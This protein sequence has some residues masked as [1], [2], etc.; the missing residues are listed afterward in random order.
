MEWNEAALQRFIADETEESSKLDY[1]AAD[2][3]AKH[4]KDDITKAVSA[5]ANTEGGF[6]IYGLREHPTKKHVVEKIDPIDR[7]VFQRNGWTR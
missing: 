3:L 4:K 5:M 2:A 6:I 1:K 7:R